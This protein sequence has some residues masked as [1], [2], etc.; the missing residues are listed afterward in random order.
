MVDGVDYRPALSI[1]PSA[2]TLIDGADA[3][4]AE[5]VGR[6]RVTLRAQGGPVRVI[7]RGEPWI[8]CPI[9]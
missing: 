6:Y 2:I 8:D 1:A 7:E 5:A 3:P 9:E 4:L